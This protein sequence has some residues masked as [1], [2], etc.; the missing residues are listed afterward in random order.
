M[1]RGRDWGE[2]LDLQEDPGELRNRYDD[3]EYAA[4]KHELAMKL[5]QAD[6]ERE[7]APQPRV[8]GA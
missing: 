3:P 5:I 6:L 1:Y 8:A 7:P 4:V 2:F